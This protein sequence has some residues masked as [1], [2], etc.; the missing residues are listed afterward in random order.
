MAPAPFQKIFKRSKSDLRT[1]GFHNG[2]PYHDKQ[3]HDSIGCNSP[4]MFKRSLFGLV[5][6][7]NRLN[8]D[9]VDAKNVQQF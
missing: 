6:V 8:Q 2:I 7:Y 3:L 4:V 1:F 9:V 5:H